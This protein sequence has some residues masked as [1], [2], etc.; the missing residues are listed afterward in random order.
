MM[1]MHML[2]ALVDG[3]AWGT[4]FMMFLL[5][6]GALI[7]GTFYGLWTFGYYLRRKWRVRQLTKR[8]QRHT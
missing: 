7:F 6:W 4:M 1:N 2:Q 5:I 3:F 8:I